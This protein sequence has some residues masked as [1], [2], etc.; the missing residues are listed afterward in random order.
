MKIAV[1]AEIDAGEPRVAATPETVKKMLALGAEVAVEPGAGIKSEVTAAFWPSDPA[2]GRE[3]GP[4][5]RPLLRARYAVRQHGL[6]A[7]RALPHLS[8]MET[9]DV[10]DAR[11]RG[12]TRRAPVVPQRSRS[13]QGQ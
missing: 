9:L 5:G 6:I 10:T 11:S 12:G 1:A 8:P 7:A 13:D 3:P 2:P 4:D